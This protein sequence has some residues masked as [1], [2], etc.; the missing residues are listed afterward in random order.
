[1]STGFGR[2]QEMPLLFQAATT[3]RQAVDVP[4][5]RDRKTTFCPG[6]LGG[7]EWNGAAFD[8]DHNM[9]I[10]GAADWC[11]T[12]QLQRDAAAVPPV[13]QSWFG[14]VGGFGQAMDS[15]ARAKGWI[16][17]VDAENGAL[18]WKFAAPRPVLGGIT[19]TAGG[20]VFAGDMSGAFYA[21]DAESGSVLWRTALGQ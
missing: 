11:S 16:T 7:S 4:L 2:A 21:F 12:V 20:L 6:S 1:P 15:A 19:P 8:P 14:N 10:A 13:G 17:A 9:L 18:R 5:S 3:T